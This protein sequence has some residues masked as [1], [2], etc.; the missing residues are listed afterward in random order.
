MGFLR[1]ITNPRVMGDDVLN[2]HH[3]WHVYVQLVRDRRVVFATEPANIE[4]VWKSFT[5]G[6]FSGTNLWTDAYLAALAVVHNLTVVS[7]DNGFRRVTG[8]NSIIL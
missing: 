1:L 2:Q 4:Q 5:Q 8:L 3:A 6:T 7:F